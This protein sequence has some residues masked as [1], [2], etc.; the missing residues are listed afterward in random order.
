MESGFGLVLVCIVCIL[1][2]I[3]TAWFFVWLIRGESAGI[4]ERIQEIDQGLA[5][6]AM[7]LMDPEH[8]RSILTQVQP[9]ADPV[10]MILEFLKSSRES[11]ATDYMRNSD[12]TFNG[13]P[14]LIEKESI[15]AEDSESPEHH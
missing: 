12:G 5:M 3:G 7:R 10:S 11:P 14:K 4:D 13:A 1:G 9:S 6:I 15:Q 2:H 8:W